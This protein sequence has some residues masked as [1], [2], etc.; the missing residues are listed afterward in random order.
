MR[1]IEAEVVLKL[2]SQ[3][4]EF[5]IDKFAT[6]FDPQTPPASPDLPPIF[7][8]SKPT[9]SI[10]STSFRLT[11]KHGLPSGRSV[12]DA[13]A[14]PTPGSADSEF[15]CFIS[16]PPAQDPL[17]ESFFPSSPPGSSQ[18][19]SITAPIPSA[20]GLSISS[21]TSSPNS[22]QAPTPKPAPPF[23][24]HYA[25][26]YPQFQL[27]FL[28]EIRGRCEEKGNDGARKGLFG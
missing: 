22:T 3:S 15:G 20:A 10:C 9:A 24:T 4:P 18:L 7:N 5:D 19:G 13:P 16:V 14:L 11:H 26:P 17:S 27:R 1:L 25:H 28:W 6:L 2:R 12:K 21:S 8:Q 23:P